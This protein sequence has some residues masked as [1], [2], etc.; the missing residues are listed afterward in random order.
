MKTISKVLFKSL[1]CFILCE[2]LVFGDGKSEIVSR[3]SNSVEKFHYIKSTLMMNHKYMS[4][5]DEKVFNKIIVGNWEAPPRGEIRFFQNGSFEVRKYYNGK[6]NLTKGFWKT[7]NNKIVFILG[8]KKTFEAG[9]IYYCIEF[10]PSALW[11]YALTL[12]FD[13][14][15]FDLSDVLIIN[16]KDN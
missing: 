12:E 9:V 6:Y 2:H 14:N 8:E 16:F 1:I 7:K 4:P 10:F 11:N 15:A 13:R 3:P 5:F